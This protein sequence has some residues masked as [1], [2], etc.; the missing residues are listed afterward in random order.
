MANNSA[1]QLEIQSLLD[2]SGF[3]QA[4]EELKKLGVNLEKTGNDGELSLSKIEKESKK[5]ANSFLSLA[6]KLLSP[7]Q[8]S[9]SS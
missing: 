9:R 3:D 8:Q 2:G 4:K 7:M 1:V 5:T 6:Q